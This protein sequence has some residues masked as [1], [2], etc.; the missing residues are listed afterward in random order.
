MNGNGD[1]EPTAART[2]IGMPIAAFSGRA[3]RA[4]RAVWN[5]VGVV[6][7]PQVNLL[8]Q[9]ATS[10]EDCKAF[11]QCLYSH[12]EHGPHR[13]KAA[14]T[15]REPLVADGIQPVTVP[16]AEDLAAGRAAVERAAT[17]CDPDWQRFYRFAD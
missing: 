4:G 5:R 14:D 13:D 2:L 1:L 12:I 17:A 9:P 3:H 11:L 16:G 7:E 15:E 6:T 10:E 8:R